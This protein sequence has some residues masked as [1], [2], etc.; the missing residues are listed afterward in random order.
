MITVA[1]LRYDSVGL[2]L[3]SFGIFCGHFPYFT[4][5]WYTYLV[6]IWEISPFLVRCA[7]KNLATLAMINILTILVPLSVPK[8][9]RFS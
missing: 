6:V 1:R 9:W 4:V 3:W 5:I 2:F 7:K 8:I